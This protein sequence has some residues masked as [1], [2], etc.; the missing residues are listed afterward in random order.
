[1]VPLSGLEIVIV[2]NGEEEAWCKKVNLKVLFDDLCPSVQ[3]Y[4]YSE[5]KKSDLKER[6]L[7]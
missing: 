2:G 4:N 3:Y 7:I 1:M 5:R 6:G